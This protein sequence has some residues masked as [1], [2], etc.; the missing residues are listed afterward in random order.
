MSSPNAKIV[1]SAIDETKKGVQDAKKN[2]QSLAKDIANIDLKKALSVTGVVAG[3]TAAIKAVSKSIKECSKEFLEASKVSTRFDAVWKNV[4]ATTGKTSEQMKKLA[5]NLELS[6][7]FTAEAT[8]EAGQLLAATGKLSKEGFDKAIQS[9][10]DLA[11]AMGTDITNAAQ[12]LAKALQDPEK[13]L[14][15]LKTAG[16][17]FTD[18]EENLIKKLEDEGRTW[19]AQ[20]LILQKVEDRYKGV[21]EALNNTPLGTAN[22][23]EDVLGNIRKGFG[24]AFVNAISPALEDIYEWLLKIQTWIDNYNEEAKNIRNQQAVGAAIGSGNISNLTNDQYQLAI[25]TATQKIAAYEESLAN[26]E[27]RRYQIGEQN[28]KAQKESLES[29]LANARAVIDNIEIARKEAVDARKKEA[30]FNKAN[31]LAME[32]MFD[33]VYKAFDQTAYNIEQAAKATSS[34]AYKTWADNVTAKYKNY[35]RYDGVLDALGNYAPNIDP[36]TLGGRTT[37]HLPP[38]EIVVANPE[39][40]G[41]EISTPVA[42]RLNAIKAAAEYATSSTM[43]E[44]WKQM[45]VAGQRQMTQLGIDPTPKSK[46]ISTPVADRLRAEAEKTAELIAYNTSDAM[47]NR[48][49]NMTAAGQKQMTQLGIDPTPRKT[50]DAVL[51]ET[52]VVG[53]FKDVMATLDQGMAPLQ[54]IR[55]MLDGVAGSLANMLNAAGPLGALLWAAKEVFGAFISQLSDLLNQAL[56]PFTEVLHW[57]GR[58]LANVFAPILDLVGR[59]LSLIGNLLQTVLGPIISLISVPLK[60][61][62]SLLDL[63][64]PVLEGVAKAFAYLFAPVKWLADLFTW[65][66]SILQTFVHN[67][68][69]PFDK[70]SYESFSSDAFTSLKSQ[71]TAVENIGGGYG[72]LVT[73]GSS[74]TG[75]ANASYTGG[76][77]VTINLY[78]QAPV[79][80]DGGMSQFARMIRAEFEELAY[81]SA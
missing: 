58:E 5:S 35:N 22:N 64:T 36:A 59:W 70:R 27:K 71:T 68:T 4:G 19:E 7:S 66:G 44:R 75:L 40:I 45:T 42:D 41:N 28:Y 69:H 29:S 33:P 49:K 3:T 52:S 51:E 6:S 11:T 79:V 74:S 53:S 56:A 18:S 57:I 8:L 1:I 46:E 38:V 21:T 48:W 80:G 32:T 9:S 50:L 23:I 16:I 37:T 63:L 60:M 14:N 30:A 76:G 47:M 61:I 39:E 15:S 26:L 54:N 62:A 31:A 24:E 65:V 67:I 25:D 55:D 77:S 2:I 20:E 17:T 34:D 10:A 12:T 72:E 43:Q 78:Q 73:T 81:Y 13:G